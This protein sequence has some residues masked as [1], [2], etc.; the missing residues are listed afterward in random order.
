MRKAVIVLATVGAVALTGIASLSPAEAR[1]GFGRGGFGPALAGGLIAGA[2]IGGL[3]SSAYGGGPAMD[4]PAMVTMVYMRLSIMAPMR[5]LGT[6]RLPI[7]VIP[8]TTISPS[9]AASRKG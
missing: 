2:V 1:G 7:T 5:S 9:L 3:A 8:T 6:V 4:T